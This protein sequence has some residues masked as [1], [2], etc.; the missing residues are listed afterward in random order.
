MRLSACRQKE[1]TTSLCTGCRVRLAT[2]QAAR[3]L[4]PFGQAECGTR[5][6]FGIS[7][8]ARLHGQLGSMRSPSLPTNTRSPTPRLARLRPPERQPHAPLLPP[9][10]PRFPLQG[11]I[12]IR[13]FLDG[14]FFTLRWW[15]SLFRRVGHRA[16]R[17]QEPTIDRVHIDAARAPP[18]A[19]D[20][21]LD[22]RR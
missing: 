1:P 9:A 15:D 20:A 11:I 14:F 12:V 21:G 2:D 4:R 7:P 18:P 6:E 22:E 5:K 3:S 16:L 8:R 19:D 13:D 17:R 10:Q